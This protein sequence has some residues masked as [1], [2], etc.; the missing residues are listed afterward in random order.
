MAHQ[1]EAQRIAASVTCGVALLPPS[2]P[3]VM[4]AYRLGH[5]TMPLP[6]TPPAIELPQLAAEFGPAAQTQAARSIVIVHPRCAE[7]K[8]GEIVV[9][10]ADP[11]R[12]RLIPLP[13]MPEEALPEARWQVSDR[14]S[15]VVHGETSMISGVPSNRAMVGIKIGF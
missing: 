7:G 11:K 6:A 15:V 2:S 10:A 12:D 8:P 13:E 1:G 14:A 5:A 4:A 9:C 3:V